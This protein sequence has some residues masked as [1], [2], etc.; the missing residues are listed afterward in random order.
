MRALITCCTA[1]T[2]CLLKS[3]QSQKIQ[4]SQRFIYH[5]SG[6]GVTIELLQV[7]N[8]A[9]WELW[10]YNQNTSKLNPWN[11]AR[12]C[13][14]QTTAGGV[15]CVGDGTSLEPCWLVDPSR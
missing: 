10:R 3:Y 8:R 6:A 1:L 14:V 7:G 15:A 4:S 11:R 9:G 12:S 5:G 13:A 2:G